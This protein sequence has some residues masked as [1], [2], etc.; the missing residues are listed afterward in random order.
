MAEDHWRVIH[1]A[2]CVCFGNIP[3]LVPRDIYRHVVAVVTLLQLLRNNFL[4]EAFVGSL[5]VENAVESLA[6]QRNGSLK[7]AKPC[8]ANHHTPRALVAIH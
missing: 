7:T 1:M 8:I 6:G 2:A 4:G 5:N 3:V